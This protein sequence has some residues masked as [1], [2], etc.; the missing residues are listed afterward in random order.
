MT[1]LRFESIPIVENHEPLVELSSYPFI[2]EPVYFKQG[3]CL[4]PKIYLRKLVADKL[5]EAQQSLKHFKFKIWDG[6]RSRQVQEKIY[7]KFYFQVAEQRPDWTEEQVKQE[8]GKF[9]TQ[10]DDYL[11]IP[12]HSTGGA[13]DLTLADE[14]DREL[15]MGTG[16][17][18][19]GSEASAL[20]Y[21]KN[22]I[23]DKIKKN[24]RRLR[25]S[26]LSAGFRMDKDEWWHFDYGNQLWAF[27]L[28]KPHA[29]YGELEK[30]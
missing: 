26:L 20:Y 5:L 21:E 9:I 7:Q 19:F 30:N 13:V 17:D 6:Y 29:F 15:E 14:R 1:L 24:R 12:P 27:E 4:T 2:L 22:S 8:I 16:F 28:N 11:R 23:D 10:A 3:L 25:E 18:F